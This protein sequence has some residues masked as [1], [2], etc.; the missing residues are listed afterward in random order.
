MFINIYNRTYI[1]GQQ[2]DR[3]EPSKQMYSTRIRRAVRRE[4]SV[5]FIAS[6]QCCVSVHAR[7]SPFVCV[8]S[9]QRLLA[10]SPRS[11]SGNKLPHYFQPQNSGMWQF[12]SFLHRRASPGSPPA[13]ET[14]P[15]VCA[16]TG[17]VRHEQTHTRLLNCALAC[18][19]AGPAE[20]NRAP[21]MVFPVNTPALSR[22]VHK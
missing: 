3:A 20:A 21:R 16:R 1:F 19:P 22:C 11:S 6:T 8:R 7:V 14:P 10:P 17:H 2:D 5:Q 15:A 9:S 12:N 13:P 4:H 18:I